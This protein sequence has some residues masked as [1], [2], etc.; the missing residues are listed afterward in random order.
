MQT[1]GTVKARAFQGDLGACSARKFWNLVCQKALFIHSERSHLEVDGFCKFKF[2]FYATLRRK[3]IAAENQSISFVK[4][5]FGLKLSILH[6]LLDTFCQFVLCNVAKQR[7]C[8]GSCNLK[9]VTKIITKCIAGFYFQQQFLQ[10]ISQQFQPLQG[11]LHASIAHA[12]CL[13]MVL[14]NNLHK[15]FPYVTSLLKLSMT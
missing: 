3:T 12:A 1:L 5:L 11:V 9:F 6:I 8:N 7:Q 10:L 2:L 13:V 15:K 14:Q 4:S